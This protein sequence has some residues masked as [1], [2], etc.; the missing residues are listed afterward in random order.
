MSNSRASVS[1]VAVLA[2]L[3]LTLSCSQDGGNTQPGPVE[4]SMVGSVEF[5]AG[6]AVDLEGVVISFGDHQ[7]SADPT[8]WFTIQGNEGLPGLA[9][10]CSEGDVP[11][12]VIF[13][14]L[15]QVSPPSRERKM[16]PPGPPLVRL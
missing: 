15:V 7:A 12:T 1:L 6:E 9:I 10:A 11:F 8:G 3:L 5:P 14:G 4:V 2:A 13:L 16:P